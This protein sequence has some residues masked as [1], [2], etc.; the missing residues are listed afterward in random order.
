MH[1][2]IKRGLVCII[3]I[4]MVMSQNIILGFC[5]H[6]QSFFLEQCPCQTGKCDHCASES[7]CPCENEDEGGCS[8]FLF[9]DLEDFVWE[10]E[11]TPS[12]SGLPNHAPDL[13]SASSEIKIPRVEIEDRYPSNFPNAP[14][15]LFG[16]E[17]LHR[18]CVSTT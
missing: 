6:H 14:P 5:H 1:C 12:N 3:T 16:V 2:R 13:A 4:T 15:P 7:S 10:K 8:N 9:L 11:P 18:I 17:L